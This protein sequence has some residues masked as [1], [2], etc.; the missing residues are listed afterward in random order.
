MLPGDFLCKNKKN[1]YEKVVDLQPFCKLFKTTKKI[2][3]EE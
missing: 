3:L 1:V 2:N